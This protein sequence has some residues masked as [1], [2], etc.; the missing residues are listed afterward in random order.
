MERCK[1][2]LSLHSLLTNQADLNERNR[3]GV[4]WSQSTIGKGGLLNERRVTSQTAYS[5][6]LSLY[7]Q[8]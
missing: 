4:A 8:L 6:S 1:Y 5:E 2:R 7:L 3:D